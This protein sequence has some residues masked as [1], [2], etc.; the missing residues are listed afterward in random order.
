M[1]NISITNLI[2]SR[3]FYNDEDVGIGWY[4]TIDNVYRD[5]GSDSTNLELSC[6]TFVKIS[7]M[8]LYRNKKVLVTN[9]KD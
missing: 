6:G 2:G 9:L 7:N 4:S 3:F 5:W 1:L 8:D